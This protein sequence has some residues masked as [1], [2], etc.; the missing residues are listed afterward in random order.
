MPEIREVESD[1]DFGIDIS[2]DDVFDTVPIFASGELK[3]VSCSSSVYDDAE[4]CN[5]S[6]N[7]ICNSCHES[8][9]KHICPHRC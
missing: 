6:A 3:V 4:S 8:Y 5:M 7:S 1:A 2:D 9:D